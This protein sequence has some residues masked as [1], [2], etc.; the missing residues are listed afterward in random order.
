MNNRLSILLN[1]LHERDPVRYDVYC[2][3]VKV[4]G[5]AGLIDQIN[6]SLDQVGEENLCFWFFLKFSY[7]QIK[8]YIAHIYN[9]P[10]IGS[11]GPGDWNHWIL[12]YKFKVIKNNHGAPACKQGHSDKNLLLGLLPVFPLVTA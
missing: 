8:L 12:G 7:I 5:K 11:C 1:W 6:V 10:F 2:T 4:A 9:Y 3:Q